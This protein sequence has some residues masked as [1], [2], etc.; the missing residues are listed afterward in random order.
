MPMIYDVAQRQD[1][2]RLAAGIDYRE[3]VNFMRAHQAVRG[4]EIVAARA[5]N[6]FRRHRALDANRCERD[7]LRICG[8]ADIAVGDNSDELAVRIDDRRA[9]AI[10]IPHYTGG[11]IQR[12]MYRAR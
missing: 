7:A 2:D 12:V 9:S 8:H 10:V 1:S 6:H 3:A 11:S 5:R 4:L